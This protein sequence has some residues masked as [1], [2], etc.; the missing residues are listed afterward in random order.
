MAV[1]QAVGLAEGQEVR[2][3]VEL[4]L[5]EIPG[6]AGWFGAYETFLRGI[7]PPGVKRS[8]LNPGFVVAAGALGGEQ[9]R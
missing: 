2:V 5:R 4:V 3:G 8:E 1:P 9:Y 6:T 7:T